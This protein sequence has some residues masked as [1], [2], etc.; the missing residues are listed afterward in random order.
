MPIEHA[1]GEEDEPHGDGR[2]GC[3]ASERMLG[4]RGADPETDDAPEQARD[5]IRQALRPSRLGGNC[6]QLNRSA[7]ASTIDRE[8]VSSAG[9]EVTAVQERA[10]HGEG[11]RSVETEDAIAGVELIV[12]RT[13]HRHSLD[14]PGA[15][16]QSFHPAQ[17]RAAA[18]S[19]HE[20]SGAIAK[21][22]HGDRGAEPDDHQERVARGRRGVGRVIVASER[23]SGLSETARGVVRREQSIHFAAQRD[24]VLAYIV[25]KREPI[26]ALVVQRL[27]KDRRNVPPLFRRHRF[28][29]VRCL[30]DVSGSSILDWARTGQGVEQPRTRELPIAFDGGERKSERVAGFLQ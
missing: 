30:S 12:G 19:R 25:Q 16:L 28:S 23:G 3:E 10:E 14:M 22:G 17:C 7:L 2:S 15:R 11:R 27:V 6:I 1:D 20:A 13:V 21:R 8:R 9:C 4:P 18:R 5:E 26:R 29:P 24:I